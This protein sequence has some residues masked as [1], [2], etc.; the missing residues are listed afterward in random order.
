MVFYVESGRRWSSRSPLSP[1]ETFW[2]G[3]DRVYVWGLWWVPPL[4]RDWHAWFVQ[5]GD[6]KEGPLRRVCSLCVCFGVGV[7]ERTMH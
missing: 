2:A 7:T 4:G 5:G 3:N 6:I 1:S